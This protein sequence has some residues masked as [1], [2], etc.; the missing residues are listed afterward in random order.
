MNDRTARVP[1]FGEIRQSR[2]EGNLHCT[3]DKIDKV[4]LG[5]DER[6][7]MG[8]CTPTF[9]DAPRCNGRAKEPVEDRGDPA[10]GWRG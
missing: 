4:W 10:G 6:Q 5:S 3:M 1:S 7:C 9:S 8:P 2:A